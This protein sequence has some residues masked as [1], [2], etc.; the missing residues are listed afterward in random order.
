MTD[1]PSRFRLKGPAHAGKVGGWLTGDLGFV[2]ADE[3]IEHIV[4]ADTF[5]WRLYRAGAMLMERVGESGPVIEWLR[6]E[7]ELPQ[8]VYGGQRL[9]R[10]AA[11]L[12]EGPFRQRLA[13]IIGVRALLPLAR[14]RSRT[15]TLQLLD[16]KGKTVLLA[17]V[18]EHR[19]EGDT[20]GAGRVVCHRLRLE[21]VRGYDKAARRVARYLADKRGLTPLDTDLFAQS[22]HA[23]K[24][25]PLDYTSKLAVRLTPQMSA[26]AAFRQIL[27]TLL[28]MLE[29]NLNGTRAHLDPEFLHDLRVSVRRTRAALGQIRGVLPAEALAPFREGF[30]WLGKVTGPARDMDVYVERFDSYRDTLPDDSRDALTPFLHFLLKHQREAQDLLSKH[31]ES[32]RVKT[33]LADWRAY[34]KAGP[35]PGQTREARAPVRTVAD[36]RIWRVYRKIIR[37]GRAIGRK[38]PATDLHDLRIECKKLRYLMEFFRSLYPARSVGRL[39]GALKSLQDNLGDFQDFEVQAHSL[40]HFSQQMVEEGDVPHETILAMGRLAAALD[41]RQHSSRKAFAERFA[42]FDSR[43]NRK[44]FKAMFRPRKKDRKKRSRGS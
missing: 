10:F 26:D 23:R 30:K 11:D 15:V 3:R 19:L 22:L 21:P 44:A 17:S 29:T 13:K 24:R 31:L 36:D 37:R 38:S 33:L 41:S 14:L 4:I 43:S 20:S 2:A 27:L 35:G 32:R 16:G 34:L 12:P 7:D 18:E 1:V 28:D 25:K 5:D 8:R 39:I 6:L 40:R 42:A 9:P